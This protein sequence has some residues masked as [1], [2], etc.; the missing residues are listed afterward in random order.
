MQDSGPVGSQ[1]FVGDCLPSLNSNRYDMEKNC[2]V[3]F[4]FGKNL[5]V[6][7]LNTLEIPAHS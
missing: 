7:I 5:G 6:Y 1:V 3:K 2:K 4:Q